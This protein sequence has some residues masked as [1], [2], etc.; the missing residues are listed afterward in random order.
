MLAFI[1]SLASFRAIDSI[2]A[3][4]HKIKFLYSFAITAKCLKLI[5]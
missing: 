4:A 2:F 5:F 3:T 1:L